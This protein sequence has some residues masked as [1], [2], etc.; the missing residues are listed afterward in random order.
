MGGGHKLVVCVGAKWIC[1]RRFFFIAA[2]FA[3]MGT[4]TRGEHFRQ[5][6]QS[7]PYPVPPFPAHRVKEAQCSP[8]QCRARRRRQRRTEAEDCLGTG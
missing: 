5:S 2:V 8:R 4:P 6:E 1:E 3:N 7:D